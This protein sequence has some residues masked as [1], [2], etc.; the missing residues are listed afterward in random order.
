MKKGA[1]A[2]ISFGAIIW[3]L[4]GAFG[5]SPPAEGR[6]EFIFARF[7]LY[8]FQCCVPELPELLELI[9]IVG[10]D[11]I[12]LHIG[13]RQLKKERVRYSSAGNIGL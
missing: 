9:G 7:L 3:F 5:G 6:M 11:W 10:S 1:V 4:G 8:G 13:G 12:F 2:P